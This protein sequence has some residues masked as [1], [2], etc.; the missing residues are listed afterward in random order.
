[1]AEL[2]QQSPSR[3]SAPGIGKCAT[4]RKSNASGRKARALP[5]AHL[6]VSALDSQ[7][8]RSVLV[9]QVFCRRHMS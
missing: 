1:M 4:K 7:I 6:R 2:E 8:S 5:E 3:D 9:S